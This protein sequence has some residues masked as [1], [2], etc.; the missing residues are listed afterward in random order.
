MRSDS[1]AEPGRRAAG[2]LLS[3]ALFAASA[4]L[5][6][7][8]RPGWQGYKLGS[9]ESQ[10]I[11]TSVQL[12]RQLV[13]GGSPPGVDP[14]LDPGS[15]HPWR[16]GIHDSNWG[17]NIPALPKL[18]WGTVLYLAGFRDTTLKALPAYFDTKD[19]YLEAA[20]TLLPLMPWARGAS[21]VVGAA[22]AVLIFWIAWA[23]AG[24]LAALGAWGLWIASPLVFE[25]VSYIRLDLF[26]LL[27][28]LAAL[29]V[30]IL[31]RDA[32]GGRRGATKMVA[33][34]VILGLLSG[35]AVS[36]K[37]NGAYNCAAVALWLALL[38]L[39]SGKERR[40]FLRGPLQALVLSGCASFGVF[41]ALNP[42]L[43]G[44]PIGGVEIILQK[45]G[46]LGPMLVESY[47]WEGGKAH[48]LG[49]RIVM[50]AEWIPKFEPLSHWAVHPRARTDMPA[51][52]V[53][54]PLGLVVLLAQA[55]AARWRYPAECDPEPA[56]IMAIYMVTSFAFQTAWLPLMIPRYFLPYQPTVVILEALLGAAVI[57]RS[58]LWLRGRIR[59][60]L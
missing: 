10:Y 56:R 25:R 46:K 11:V 30:A 42:A 57:Y 36:S 5:F 50:A 55:F 24:R 58:M 52:V 6:Y 48:T 31:A 41:Y 29:L 28:S 9:D 17:Y 8:L 7:L 43:W 35:L 40:P 32:L 20:E 59:S 22:T 23:L 60:E 16:V 18:V 3:V 44:D 37:L 38:W 19:E 27:F 33:V 14:D 12:V 13:Q 21:L 45:W 34:A 39:T 47:G 53:L 26:Q 4:S 2:L 49:E 54:L 15:Y 51:G 1:L